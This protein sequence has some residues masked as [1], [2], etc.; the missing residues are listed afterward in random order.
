MVRKI[1][2]II[3]IAGIAALSLF[4]IKNEGPGL[5]WE[6]EGLY[7]DL[8]FRDLGKSLN[9]CLAA[10]QKDPVLAEGTFL[11]ANKWFSGWSC[12]KVG[13]PDAIL[14]LNYQPEKDRYYYCDGPERIIGEIPGTSLEL[15]NIE[16]LET[17]DQPE[18]K[19]L[20]CQSFTTAMEKVTHNKRLLIHC[21]AGR[22]RTGAVSAL[23]GGLALESHPEFSHED[24]LA[25]VEC[26]YIKSDSLS[27]NKYGRMDRFLRRIWERE[28]SIGEFLRSRCDTDPQLIKDFQSKMTG[29]KKA[30]IN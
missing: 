30:A 28:Q 11:R 5:R 7:L 29:T 24:I 26:D 16:F 3:A 4:L 13:S 1:S 2:W 8:N 22:D 19:K 6:P 15:N 9:V 18:Q 25:A 12:D 10:R 17:W 21:E 27:E 14:S 20:I 23:L